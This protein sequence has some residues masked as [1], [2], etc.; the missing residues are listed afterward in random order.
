MKLEE[1]L[2]ELRKGRR[3]KRKRW[4]PFYSCDEIAADL[5]LD[6]Q[7][8]L[9]DDWELEPLPPKTVTITREELAKA[10]NS[11]QDKGDFQFF[12][13]SVFADNLCKAL[14]LGEP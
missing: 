10:W 14:G 5:S 6:T 1:I 12:N 3:A 7:S 4:A 8:I 11:V 13:N 9:A 2:P